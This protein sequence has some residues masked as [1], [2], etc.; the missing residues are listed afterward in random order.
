MSLVVFLPFSPASP[1]SPVCLTFHH[2]ST[3]ALR[4]SIVCQDAR[5]QATLS[6]GSKWHCRRGY[7]VSSGIPIM[8]HTLLHSGISLDSIYRLSMQT[9]LCIQYIFAFAH[10]SSLTPYLPLPLLFHIRHTF[11]I[12]PKRRFPLA[13]PPSTPCHKFQSCSSSSSLWARLCSPFWDPGTEHTRLNG[14]VPHSSSP[15]GTNNND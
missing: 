10:P 1:S 2:V 8:P 6:C 5:G 12:P 14:S 3:W 9:H 13:S 11:T 4:S 7:M 15:C